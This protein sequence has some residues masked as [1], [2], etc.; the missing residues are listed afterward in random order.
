M[1]L[2][3]RRRELREEIKEIQH[4]IDEITEYDVTAT[5][6]PKEQL[7]LGQFNEV[8]ALLKSY[9]ENRLLEKE[10][11]LKKISLEGII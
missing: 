8:G 1:S 11:V 9:Y 5:D 10:G 7:V 2:N 6:D 3:E 4:R